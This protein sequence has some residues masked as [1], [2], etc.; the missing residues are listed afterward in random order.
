M[1]RLYAISAALFFCTIFYSGC[2]KPMSILNKVKKPQGSAQSDNDKNNTPADDIARQMANEEARIKSALPADIP[3]NLQWTMPVIDGKAISIFVP[4]KKLELP[5]MI[6]QTNRNSYI[7][8]DRTNG[9]V[10]WITELGGTPTAPPDFTAFSTY[11][12]IDNHLINLARERGEVIWKLQLDFP[13]TGHLCAFEVDRDNPFF[14]MPAMDRLVYGYNTTKSVWPPERGV[15]T[16]KREDIMIERTKLHMLWKY[17]TEGLIE[18]PVAYKGGFAYITDSANKVY[19]VN[20]LAITNNRPDTAW[21]GITRGPNPGGIIVGGAYAVVASRDQNIYCYLRRTGNLAWRYEAGEM[22]V[23]HA[24]F[25]ADPFKK[26]VAIIANA[27]KGPLLCMATQGGKVLWQRNKTGKVAAIDDEID[28]SD[29]E[30]TS[31]I[32]AYDDGSMEGVQFSTGQTVWK[33]EPGIIGYTAESPQEKSVYA[34][35]KDGK[36]VFSLRRR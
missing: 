21:K 32:I 9:R 1:N 16:I 6:V 10:L 13:S 26:E 29:K 27:K 23:K 28:K 19:A 31:I 3:L 22:F 4:E 25:V 5:F 24:T 11:T 35:T 8:V 2:D 33:S 17:P 7:A 20:S 12:I 34:I 36:T 14:V 18:G 30:R 15:G